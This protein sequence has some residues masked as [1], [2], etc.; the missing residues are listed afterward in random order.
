MSIATKTGDGGETSLM[1]GRRV[2]KSDPR[3]DTYGCVDELNAA[4]GVARVTAANGFIAEHLLGIQKELITVMGE[5]A[6]APEDLERYARDGYR[7]TTSAMVQSLTAIVDDLE[8]N[9]LVNYKGWAIPGSTMVSAALDVA[10][11]TCR[12]AERRVA[13]LA[14]QQ[15]GVNPEILRYLN[16]LSDLCWLLAR[17]A[18]HTN[19]TRP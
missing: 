5:L 18:E 15:P 3:V 1:Y 7:L 11:T 13:V 12:R 19:T 2:A 14:E 17:Y 16:R 9:K 10:R 4:L 6:T 8:K